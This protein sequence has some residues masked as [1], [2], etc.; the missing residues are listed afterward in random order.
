MAFTPV[1]KLSITSGAAMVLLSAVGL[2]SYLSTMQMVDAQNAAAHTNEVIARLDR[3]LLRTMAAEAAARKYL[4]TGDTASVHLLDA[5]Q[6]DVEYALD[7]L[8]ADTEDHPEQRRHLD[9]LGPIV[10][11]LLHDARQVMLVRTKPGRDSAA[12][13]ER[14]G[15]A[16]PTPTRLLAEMRNEE[17]RVLGEKTRLMTASGK[18]S[19]MLVIFGSLFAFVLAL[20][21]LQPLRSSV[22]RRLTQRLSSVM[23][24]IPDDEPPRG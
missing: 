6:G 14:D 8:R 17:V 9:S 15:P 12:R 3:V 11:T 24:S 1:Q 23:T 7:S 21:A 18:T 2:V 19:R 13:V 10:G 22:E 16:R 20:I 5:A 4:A